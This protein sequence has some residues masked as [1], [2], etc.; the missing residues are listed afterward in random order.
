MIISSS[1][2]SDAQLSD[3]ESNREL[4]TAAGKYSLMHLLDRNSSTEGFGGFSTKTQGSHPN[5]LFQTNR[6][7]PILI[8]IIPVSGNS[9]FP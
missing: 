3:N 9:N 5:G 6:Q 4:D 1:G 8:P 7:D 2:S